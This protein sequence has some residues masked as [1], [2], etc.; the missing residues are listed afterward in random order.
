MARTLEL[1]FATEMGG[2]ARLVID[3][4]KEP[5]ELAIVK[6]AMNEIINSGAFYSNT[7]D[8]VAVKGAR[9]IERKVTDYGI[10]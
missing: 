2:T 10:L 9:L 4:P 3:N 5:I 6:Q 7:G 1:S 8:Y